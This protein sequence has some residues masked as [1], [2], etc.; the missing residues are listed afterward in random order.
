MK[1]DQPIIIL[2]HDAV[3]IKKLEFHPFF[4]SVF[5]LGCQEYTKSMP[6]VPI[7]LYA[8]DGKNNLFICRAHAYAI[9]PHVAKNMLSYVLQHGIVDPLDFLIRSDLFSIQYDGT[10]YAYDMPDDTTILNRDQR[11]ESGY[12]LAIPNDNLEI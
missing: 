5:Y 12:R 11:S 4:N 1:I 2:E 3:M 10:I 8:S 7:P 9:D 6:S